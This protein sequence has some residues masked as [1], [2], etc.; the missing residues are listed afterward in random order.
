MDEDFTNFDAQ[1]RSLAA[2]Y[3]SAL[4]SGRETLKYDKLERKVL[5]A[6]VASSLAETLRWV[7]TEV[8]NG[9]QRDQSL[10]IIA[11][12]L[13]KDDYVGKSLRSI[14]TM[15][16][17]QARTA[18][19]AL[20]GHGAW[21]AWV[22]TVV[23]IIG[24]A[25]SFSLQ[26]GSGIG[27]VI[28]LAILFVSVC[29]VPVGFLMVRSAPALAQGVRTMSNSLVQTFEDMKNL[30]KSA[31]TLGEQARR[32]FLVNLRPSLN[33]IFGSG[34]AERL[35]KP[36]PRQLQVLANAIL[37]ITAIFAIV[38]IFF[39]LAGLWHGFSV[40]NQTCHASGP[41]HVSC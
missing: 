11:K 18:A 33:A 34:E 14:R 37:I 32:I 2:A 19:L 8:P 25:F 28:A 41:N 23:S 4:R 24:A 16:S 10:Q 35:S 27:A 21:P 20:I 39:F 5:Q 17:S 13:A 3:N 26:A 9:A 6:I 31:D 1:I 7:H 40:V 15:A 30:F 29:S 36:I 12:E 38:C 22:A